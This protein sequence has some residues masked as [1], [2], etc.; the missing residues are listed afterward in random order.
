MISPRAMAEL[1]L[2]ILR[3]VANV[4]FNFRTSEPRLL[5]LRVGQEFTWAFGGEFPLFGNQNALLL[6]V[7]VTGAVGFANSGVAGN[8]V[9][10]LAGVKYRIGDRFAIELGAGGGLTRGWGA[11]RWLVVAGLS[12]QHT[13]LPLPASWTKSEEPAKPTDTP[14]REVDT[15]AVAK[16]EP[17]P[18]EAKPAEPA[19]PAV[20]F[21]DADRDGVADAD[22]KCPSERETINGNQDGDGCPDP[23]EGKVSLVGGKLQLRAKVEFTPRKAQP[24]PATEG[25]LKQLALLLKANPDKKVRFDVFVTEMDTSNANAAMSTER[26]EALTKLLSAEGVAAG[27]IKGVAHGMERPLEASSVE[28][29]VY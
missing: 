13:P 21:L 15:W 3:L 12:Y 29:A 6:Q 25:L 26:L 17:K 2:P 24:N 7:S 11:P 27:R 1:T 19:R 8:P 18:T 10:A 22:D 5:N 23:G 4:G 16:P 9:D 14:A 20:A 28:V